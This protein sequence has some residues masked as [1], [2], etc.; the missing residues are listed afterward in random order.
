M[1][2]AERRQMATKLIRGGPIAET[3]RRELG[4]VP[5]KATARYADRTDTTASGEYTAGTIEPHADKQAD[6]GEET[7]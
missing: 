7:R 6:E 4:H 3:V 5:T 2:T 1:T